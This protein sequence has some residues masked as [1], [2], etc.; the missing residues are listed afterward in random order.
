MN[1]FTENL[2][3]F[4]ETKPLYSWQKF[5][6]SEYATEFT[7]FAPSEFNTEFT[8]LSQIEM[9]CPTCKRSRP[10]GRQKIGSGHNYSHDD[11]DDYS[12]DDPIDEYS[13]AKVPFKIYP[14]FFKCHTC[15]LSEYVFFIEVDIEN[16]KIRKIGQSPPWLL[17]NAHKDIDR[18]LKD[19]AVFFQRALICQSQGYGIA[20]F[21]YYRRIV[22][23]SIEKILKSISSFLEREGH[24]SDK[25]RQIDQALKEPVMDQKIKIAK[26]AIPE[27]LKQDGI[28]PLGTIYNTLSNGI[29]RL[30]EE[31]CLKKCEDIQV[32]LSYLIQKLP[33]QNEEQ[34]AYINA[35]KRLND[36]KSKSS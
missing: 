23:N 28:N 14:F 5:E 4:F 1:N 12:H 21:S 9:E 34:R 27:S 33:E 8:N 31:E 35:L 16:T 10:F 29:H 11:S 24:S 26:D 13:E 25:I 36:T 17:T 30:P 7:Y 6:L 22:E 3:K 18:F 32:A 15:S 2:R 20:A 19:D